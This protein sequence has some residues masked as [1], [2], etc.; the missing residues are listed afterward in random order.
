MINLNDVFDGLVTQLGEHPAF[1]DQ[2]TTFTRSE[3][4]NDNINHTPWVGVY[5]KH[6]TH[7]PYT[8]ATIHRRW[9]AKVTLMIVAQQSSLL[10][11]EDCSKRLEVL[12]RDTLDA[13]VNDTSFGG[14]IDMINNIGVEYS[15]EKTDRPSLHFQTGYITL[16]VELEHEQPD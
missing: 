6:V 12:I 8:L 3:C 14:A 7:D 1:V 4:V 5:T 16:E 10:S 15:F 2:K 13:L 11:G 9:K